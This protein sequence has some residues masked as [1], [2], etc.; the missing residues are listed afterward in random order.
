[1]SGIPGHT[2][3]PLGIHMPSLF[4]RK[5]TKVSGVQKLLLRDACVSELQVPEQLH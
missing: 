5:V 3:L 1:M 2:H 4:L